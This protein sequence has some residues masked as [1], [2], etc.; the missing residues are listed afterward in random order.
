MVVRKK[1]PF[2]FWFP[3]ICEQW[4]SDGFW[5]LTGDSVFWLELERQLLAVSILY[6]VISLKQKLKGGKWNI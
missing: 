2:W 4:W 5:E 1:C 6:C 3:N